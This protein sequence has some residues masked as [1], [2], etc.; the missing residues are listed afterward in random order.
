MLWSQKSIFL[1]GFL[2]LCNSVSEISFSSHLTCV[3]R[4]ISALYGWRNTNPSGFFY[5]VILQVIQGTEYHFQSLKCSS[6]GFLPHLWMRKAFAEPVLYRLGSH[7]REGL[8]QMTSWHLV[9]FLWETEI[10][11]CSTWQLFF[12]Y[13]NC[14]TVSFLQLQSCFLPLLGLCNKWYNALG[15]SCALNESWPV[16]GDGKS[17]T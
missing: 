9:K 11:C 16:G 4:M 17:N 13:V 15:L 12:G 2:F 7:K 10:E 1:P 14:K 6:R 5:N 8:L 3:R